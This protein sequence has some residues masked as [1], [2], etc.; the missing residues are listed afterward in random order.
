MKSSPKLNIKLI[1]GIRI[2]T[3]KEFNEFSEFAVSKYFSK[4][5][6]YSRVLKLLSELH[7]NEFNQLDN[8]N[9][10][11]GLSEKLSIGKLTLQNRLSELYKI[12][13]MFLITKKLEQSP[14]DRNKFLLE[15]YLEKKLHKLFEY[16]YNSSK[17]LL[18]KKKL[19]S[20]LLND[21]CQIQNHAALNLFYTG[22]YEHF[23]VL[24][25]G[26]SNYTA[27]KFLDDILKQ[28]IESMNQRIHGYEPCTPLMD[29]VLKEINV[30]SFLNRLKSID[31]RLF[32]F[33]SILYNMYL[34]F[35]DFD[36]T[37]YFYKARKIHENIL[38]ELGRDENQYIYFLMIT[39]CINQ[40]NLKKTKFY[41]ELFEIINEK[42]NTGYF[43]ELK[44]NNLPVN[45]FRDYVITG[46]RIGEINWVKLF[47]EKYSHYLP[48]GFR[49]DEI[50]IGLGI[51]ALE[52]KRF[53]QA[54]DFLKKI[55][56]KNYLHY[57]DSA[58]Y[59]LRAYYGLKLYYE[60]FIEIDRLKQ[61]LN[62]HKKIPPIYRNLFLEQLNDISVLFKYRNKQIKISDLRYYFKDI[63]LTGKKK[64]LLDEVKKILKI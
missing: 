23:L 4:E 34:S 32:R 42:L 38:Q 30:E 17:S 45:N 18:K 59:K 2:L 50:N 51:I 31:D 12:L 7:K 10:L 37:E 29:Q 61:Y 15:I 28:S 48:A 46:I 33:L 3:A 60:S 56:K 27:A 55:R 36:N 43:D 44:E 26:N 13:E 8:K 58:Y 19:S 39:Y 63:D 54:I 41:R 35:K 57:F 21:T 11:S 20:K 1:Q 16:V 6:E 47:V 9:L 52:E 25:A 53:V 64:W 40:T 24:Y 62:Y 14:E 49:N 5:R 22:N